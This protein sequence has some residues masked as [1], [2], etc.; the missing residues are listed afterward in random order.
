MEEERW[1]KR[2]GGREG[3]RKRRERR[4]KTRRGEKEEKEGGKGEEEKQRKY[5]PRL[6]HSMYNPLPFTLSLV[7]HTG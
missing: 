1:R 5:S 6:Q 3:R 7:P 4:R 2:D